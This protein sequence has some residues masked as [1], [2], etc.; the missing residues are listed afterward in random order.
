[1]L[2]AS[3]FARDAQQVT[4]RRSWCKRCARRYQQQVRA[5]QRAGTELA[6]AR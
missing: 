1:V 6:A 2:P 4:G 5:S 3:E